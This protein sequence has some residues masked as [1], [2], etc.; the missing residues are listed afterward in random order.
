VSVILVASVRPL[1]EF[2]EEVAAACRE[3]ITS[4]HA[5]DGCEVYALHDSN[6]GRLVMIEKWA[7]PEALQ[8]HGES[9]VVTTMRASLD[10]KVDGPVEVIRLT[11]RPV[12]SLSQGQL[13][14]E[15]DYVG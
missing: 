3:L 14:P 15:P 12:G 1:L 4:S 13:W 7:S 10:G 6:D 8:A 11:P 9:N 2:Y 5:Q